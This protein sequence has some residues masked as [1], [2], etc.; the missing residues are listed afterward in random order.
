MHLGDPVAQAVHNHL[1]HLWV[2]DIERISRP[3]VVHVV[4]RIICNRAVVGQVV[5]A[6][7][8]TA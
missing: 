4:A 6:L 7:P 8:T 5:D 1:Q 2:V 3:G